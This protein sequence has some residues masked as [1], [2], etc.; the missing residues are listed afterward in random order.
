MGVIKEFIVDRS[1]WLNESTRGY[2]VTPALLDRGSG[3]MCFLGFAC[4]AAGA[5]KDQIEG[6]PEPVRVDGVDMPQL[7]C[8]LNNSKLSL[9]AMD[10][11]DNGIFNKRTREAK[12][13]RL[14]AEH[15]IKVKF[16]GRSPRKPFGE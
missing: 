14:F 13:R 2:N 10:I 4:L 3:A 9:D 15:G 5:T 11:N 12:L 8:G 7:M 16:V 1:K 6:V